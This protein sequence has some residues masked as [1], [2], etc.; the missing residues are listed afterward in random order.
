MDIHWGER[1][2]S[3]AERSFGVLHRLYPAAAERT[4][5]RKGTRSFM[6]IRPLTRLHRNRRNARPASISLPLSYEE[7]DRQNAETSAESS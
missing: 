7:F 2:E 1:T 3:G 4:A 6:R 5:V